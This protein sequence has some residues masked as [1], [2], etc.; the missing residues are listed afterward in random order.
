MSLS[1]L[2]QDTITQAFRPP[3]IYRH[4]KARP[5]PYLYPKI[6]IGIPGIEVMLLLA[7]C[8]KD[9]RPLTGTSIVG[10]DPTCPHTINLFQL[11]QCL[12]AA[13]VGSSLS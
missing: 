7:Q 1:A 10:R 11:G 9:D 3:L 12:G 4:R 13:K 8:P 5:V 2:Q 6:C